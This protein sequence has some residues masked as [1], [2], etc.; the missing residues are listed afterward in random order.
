[1]IKCNK[2][3]VKFA[4]FPWTVT[5]EMSV[6]VKQFINEFGND[7]FEKVLKLAMATDAEINERRIEAEGRMSD[8]A[9]KLFYI[10]NLLERMAMKDD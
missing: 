4:G 9:K 8:E 1:M 10:C 6:I 2:G 3:A 5:A 7:A